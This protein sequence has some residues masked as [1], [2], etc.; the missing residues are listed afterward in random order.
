MKDLKVMH[1]DYIK[2]QVEGSDWSYGSRWG[3]QMEQAITEWFAKDLPKDAAILDIGCGEG[4]GLD[5][6]KK[7]EFTNLYGIDLSEEKLAA[8]RLRGWQT[9]FNQDF[10]NLKDFQ[11]EFDYAFC[12]HTLEHAYD[13]KV[14]L[15]SIELV[16]KKSLYFIVPVGETREEVIKYNPSHTSP[17]KDMDE[18]DKL[19]TDMGYKNFHLFEQARMCKE[20]WGVINYA[21]T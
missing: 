10:H 3:D 11:F 1:E 20:V 14:A 15:N 21:S 17:F 18:I 8:A 2:L 19:L 16:V 9:V 7:L 5:A 13:I 12:S 4:R 6:L